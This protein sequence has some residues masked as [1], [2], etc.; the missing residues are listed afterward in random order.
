MATGSS[1]EYLPPG[2]IF[3][4]PLA[5][6]AVSAKKAQMQQQRRKNAEEVE[7]TAEEATSPDRHTN[8]HTATADTNKSDGDESGQL[9]IYS[10]YSL[11]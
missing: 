6:N 4:L 9:E 8:C 3:G 5:A 10:I 11:I 2:P 7:A 1:L